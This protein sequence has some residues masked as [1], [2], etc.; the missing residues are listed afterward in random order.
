MDSRMT[1]LDSRFERLEDRRGGDD[2]PRSL[3]LVL[4]GLCVLATP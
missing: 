4:V 2:R 1:H 3:P